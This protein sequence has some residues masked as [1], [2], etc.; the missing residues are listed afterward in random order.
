MLFFSVINHILK[1]N[2][3]KMSIEECNSNTFYTKQGNVKS[4]IKFYE[5]MKLDSIEKENFLFLYND[6]D[7]KNQSLISSTPES[8]NIINNEIEKESKKTQYVCNDD[9][10]KTT[11]DM[12]ESKTMDEKHMEDIM[13]DDKKETKYDDKTTNDEIEDEL[14]DNNI[15]NV[16]KNDD[17][18]DQHDYVG[19]YYIADGI[20]AMDD[21]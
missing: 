4:N 8:I 18:V 11:D 9:N 5:A 1:L 13:S 10:G 2:T 17:M 3:N 20:F 16:E 6:I 19:G 21:E 14:N 15:N 7:F 12:G